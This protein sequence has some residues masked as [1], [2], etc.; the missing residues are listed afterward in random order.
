MG[1][2]Y[3]ADTS[4][5]LGSWQEGTEGL[6][7]VCEDGQ[8]LM[9]SAAPVAPETQVSI[10]SFSGQ[11]VSEGVCSPSEVQSLEEGVWAGRVES[12]GVAAS[13]QYEVTLSLGGRQMQASC[14]IKVI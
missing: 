2:C 3:V 1:N 10:A 14:T 7:T 12:R 13:F 5:Y 6:H 11:M 8:Q 4:H 9:W